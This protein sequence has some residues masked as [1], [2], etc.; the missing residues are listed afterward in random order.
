[1]Y[2][3]GLKP[4]SLALSTRNS[5]EATHKMAAPERLRSRAINIRRKADNAK[6]RLFYIKKSSGFVFSL[7]FVRIKIHA[8]FSV[9]SPEYTPMRQ[10]RYSREFA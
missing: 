9:R 10:L 3:R 1:M 2:A 4:K 8:T 5:L 7:A 6:L